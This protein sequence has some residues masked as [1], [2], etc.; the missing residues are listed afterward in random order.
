MSELQVLNSV[1]VR[2][3]SI[4]FPGY[5]DLK[6]KALQVAKIIRETE[7]NEETIKTAK[8]L[9][10]EANKAVKELEDRRIGVKKQMMGP[11]L[12]FEDQVKEIVAIVKDADQEVRS[13]VR[14]LEEIERDNKEQ[15]LKEIWNTRMRPYR[16]ELEFLVFEDWLEPYHL[17][18]ST[19][20]SKIEEDMAAFLS[21]KCSD[22]IAIKSLE[23]SIDILDEYTRSLDM[24]LSIQ[25]VTQRIK[26]KEE[27]NKKYGAVNAVIDQPTKITVFYI[28]DDA[29][30]RLAEILLKDNNIKFIK[31]IK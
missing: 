25:T 10:A 8:K 3:G 6:G 11:Y 13:K 15:A 27:L 9:L 2:L 17:N 28:E 4:E 30:A 21:A 26:N 5:S 19:P 22:V 7:V 31:E 24:A 29:Q 23:N 20:I 12:E 16:D 18:K 14:E 1:Q